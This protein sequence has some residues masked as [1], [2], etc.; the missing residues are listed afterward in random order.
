MKHIFLNN[1]WLSA[2]E[3]RRVSISNQKIKDFENKQVTVRPYLLSL[4][5]EGTTQP[6]IRERFDHLQCSGGYKAE[7]VNSAA[8]VRTGLER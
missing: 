6:G 8:P 4:E 1:S 2:K 3:L 7:K 5:A